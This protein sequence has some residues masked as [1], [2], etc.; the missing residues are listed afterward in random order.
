MLIK[1]DKQRKQNKNPPI[2]ALH[3]NSPKKVDKLAN[4]V[5]VSLKYQIG[6]GGDGH[7]VTWSRPKSGSVG[8][9][10]R[11]NTLIHVIIL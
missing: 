7:S 3:D 8:I 6:K 2:V 11:N 9:Y 4:P 5:R 1:K 10:K